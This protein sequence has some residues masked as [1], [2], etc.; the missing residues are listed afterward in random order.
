MGKARVLRKPRRRRH[1]TRRA[2]ADRL[3]ADGAVGLRVGVACGVRAAIN[4][5][6]VFSCRARRHIG[7]GRA[8]RPH[9]L[10]AAG[11]TR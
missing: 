1:R 9:T 5:N 8:F 11:A 3:G 10:F 7:V 6:L 2:V 4:Q